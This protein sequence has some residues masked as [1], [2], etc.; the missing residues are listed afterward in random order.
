MTSWGPGDQEEYYTFVTPEAFNALKQWMEFR[1]E[2]GEEI[3]SESWLMR[4][5]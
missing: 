3:R 2:Y 5:L 4:D 1:A